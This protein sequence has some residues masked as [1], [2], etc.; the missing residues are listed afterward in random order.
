M[1]ACGVKIGTNAVNTLR[2]FRRSSN[3]ICCCKHQ[4][5]SCN[6]A[7]QE[8]GGVFGEV[9]IFVPDL[10]YA[11]MTLLTSR[12]ITTSRA[13]AP[14]KEPDSN[15]GNRALR[16]AIR[17]TCCASKHQDLPRVVATLLEIL[18]AINTHLCDDTTLFLYGMQCQ[19]VKL[20]SASSGQ[21]LFSVGLHSRYK[22]LCPA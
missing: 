1:I 4:N 6:N 12:A 9:S 16:L 11:G 22:L 10:W 18:Q 3:F 20:T 19:C 21:R 8:D 7:L 13:N 5:V 2:Q 14:R 15:A 17:S